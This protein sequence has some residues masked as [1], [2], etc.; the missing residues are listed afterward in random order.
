M[1]DP[2]LQMARRIYAKYMIDN[3]PGAGPDDVPRFDDTAHGVRIALA[4]IEECTERAAKLA[5]GW[6]DENKS[7]IDDGDQSIAAQKVRGAAIEMNA[8][9][10]ALRS[11]AHL[12]GPAA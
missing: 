11:G 10:R 4:A 1:T 6:R 12:K 2:K 8:F 7:S 5:I 9:A 3:T